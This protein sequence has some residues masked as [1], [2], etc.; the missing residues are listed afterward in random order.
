MK[1]RLNRVLT[2][3]KIIAFLLSISN[4]SLA[5]F[6]STI[7]SNY[8]SNHS[9]S[10][11]DNVLSVNLRE[12]NKILITGRVENDF[13]NFDISN[14]LLND[15]LD[16][17]WKNNYSTD[18]A[19]ISYDQPTD[20][21]YDSTGN[22]YV[23]GFR[24]RYFTSNVIDRYPVF[25][26]LDKNGK[27]VWCY[28]FEDF[29]VNEYEFSAIFLDIECDKL[30]NCYLLADGW[31]PGLS[32]NGRTFIMKF[33]QDGQKLWCKRTLLYDVR[34]LV[35]DSNQDIFIING[36]DEDQNSET[37]I[38]KYSGSGEL[39]S[40][41][42]YPNLYFTHIDAKID[43][44]NTLWIFSHIETRGSINKIAKDILISHYDSDGAL[45]GQKIYN[46]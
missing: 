4:T 12:N 13:S 21:V 33:D 42:R 39:I 31:Q 14:I 30:G 11:R 35:V 41:H 46:S 32:T 15:N 26:K 25:Y 5:Q 36:D 16:L 40:E 24:N 45:L 29:A 8:Y 1:T 23:A 20:V 44:K 43:K 27:K 37:I 28:L 2:P 19:E 9:V 10:S 17:V 22:I 38:Q 7:W 18:E 6:D 3:I 34:K